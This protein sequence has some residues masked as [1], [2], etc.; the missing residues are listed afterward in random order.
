[1]TQTAKSREV[2]LVGPI[3]RL[4]EQS[5]GRER[6]SAIQRFFAQLERSDRKWL[7][8]NHPELIGGVNGV[9][10]AIR[11]A[12]NRVIVAR[13]LDRVEW[14]R[15]S[16]VE[17]I[18]RRVSVLSYE[19]N[20]IARELEQRRLRH[21]HADVATLDRQIERYRELLEPRVESS[22]RTVKRQFLRVDPYALR[23][24][25]IVEVIGDLE[26]AGSVAVIIPGATQNFF[27][28]R[29]SR[30]RAERLHDACASLDARANTAIIAWTGYDSP[31]R[32]LDGLR[33]PHARSA[34]PLL[35]SDIEGLELPAHVVTTV[36]GHCYGARP[37]AHALRLGLKV[38]NVVLAGHLGMDFSALGRDDA[39]EGLRFYALLARGDWAKWF[40]GVGLDPDGIGVNAFPLRTG[41]S[42]TGHLQ[43][44]KLDSESL[45]NQ[46]QVV[47]NHPDRATYLRFAS[48][49]EPLA[50]AALSP[51]SLAVLPGAA[52]RLEQSSTRPS[53][54]PD[55]GSSGIAVGF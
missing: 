28:H 1:M 34:A 5:D 21:A 8:V 13:A 50:K 6:R 48:V 12:A 17:A 4:L 11:F 49:P 46:A 22:G 40:R 55:R 24:G 39:G 52:D 42:V 30:K 23:S 20:S 51:R 43:Y 32:K 33:S 31:Q 18:D 26:S 14:E 15:A 16:L 27:T 9:P 44:W 36:I 37:I 41:P 7:V 38:D 35:L 54:R 3:R 19:S 47:T 2:L 53:D 10:L 29:H 25:A 45:M